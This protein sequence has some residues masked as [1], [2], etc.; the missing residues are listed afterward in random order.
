MIK[1]NSCHQNPLPAPPWHSP[2][3]WHVRPKY[4]NILAKE[5]RW[6]HQSIVEPLMKHFRAMI[7][8]VFLGDASI[9]PNI[10]NIHQSR[11][12]FWMKS[13]FVVPS[14]FS[15]SHLYLFLKVVIHKDADP[16]AFPRIPRY[17][18][19]VFKNCGFF[20]GK[21]ICLNYLLKNSPKLSIKARAAVSF[22]YRNAFLIFTFEPIPSDNYHSTFFLVQ[23]T[24]WKYYQ[25]FEWTYMLSFWLPCTFKDLLKTS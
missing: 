22:R 11:E 15:W 14:H 7:W 18:E 12:D 4:E 24:F 1:E 6:A 21:M 13:D 20:L 3:W 17:L 25:S 2:V 23:V 19:P 8:K 5:M 10:P 9:L 16:Q